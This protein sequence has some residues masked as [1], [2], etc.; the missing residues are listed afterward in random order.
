VVDEP[1]AALD[2]QVIERAIGEDL[3]E[4]RRGN[5]QQERREQQRRQQQQRQQQVQPGVMQNPGPT[6]TIAPPLRG[7]Q[8]DGGAP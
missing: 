4:V 3:P 7:S 1:P 6:P 5:A 8:G 2:E